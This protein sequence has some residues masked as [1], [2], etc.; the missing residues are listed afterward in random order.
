MSD[1]NQA[2]V[3]AFIEASDKNDEAAAKEAA[4]QIGAQVLH[5]LGR[6]A[7]TLERLAAAFEEK[8][9]DS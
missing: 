4:I 3:R 6:I 8:E 5:D 7:A 9:L 2:L 1:A